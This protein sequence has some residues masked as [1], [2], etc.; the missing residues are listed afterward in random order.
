MYGAPYISIM[1]KTTI[2][3]D[4]ATHR[5]LRQLADATGRTQAHLIR[6]ALEQY[7]FGR[8]SAEPRSVGLGEGAADLSARTEALLA[9]MGEG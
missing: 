9:G 8:R 5:R 3:L 7:V 2:Y 6:E 4:E 1:H